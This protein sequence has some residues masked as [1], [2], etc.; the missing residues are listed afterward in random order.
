LSKKIK[1]LTKSFDKLI[2][3]ID[4][5]D[6]SLNGSNKYW[7]VASDNNYSDYFEAVKKSSKSVFYRFKT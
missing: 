1:T 7:K 3:T 6:L 2:G 4:T 5:Q